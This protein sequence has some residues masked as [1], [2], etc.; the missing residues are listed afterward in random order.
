MLFSCD[1]AA[2]AIICFTQKLEDLEVAGRCKGVWDLGDENEAQKR[3]PS[4]LGK[5]EVQP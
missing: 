1:R 3:S 5:Q 4:R 2:A